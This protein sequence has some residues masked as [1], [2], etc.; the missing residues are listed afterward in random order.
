VL[1][2]SASQP[3]VYINHKTID[4]KKL[5]PITRVLI[6]ASALIMVVTYFVPIWQILMWAPQYPEGL[7][8]KIWLYTLSGDYKIISGLN[9][10]I[11]MKHIEVDMFPE[12]SYMVYFVGGLM[13]FG[14][15]AAVVNRRFMLWSY[16]G[17]I[18]FA[19]VAG[20]V[21]FY[22]W[23][24]DYGHNLDPAAP[25][26][27]PGMAYQPP[28]LGT[29]QLLNFTAYSGPDFGG[30]IFALSGILAIAGIFL[31]RE[32]KKKKKPEAVVAAFAC[33][34]TLL[35]A[36]CSSGP[37][38]L[39]FGKDG[40]HFCKMT[41]MDH[42]FGS[43]VVTAK[44]KIFKFDDVTCLNSFLKS[45]EVPSDQVSEI[46]IVD[47]AKPGVFIDARNAYYVT[48]EEIKSP[49]G[50]NTAAFASPEAVKAINPKWDTSV[51]RWEDVSR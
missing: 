36:S 8:M 37:E 3:G 48:N 22:Q 2:G 33:I 30:Y 38:P 9:H 42:K 1:A 4:M 21:D 45:E 17:L 20:L 5:K 12:F 43:E 29:K 24:Y 28:L 41:L 16:L 34:T 49:M 14:V 27:V 25:I 46:V 26:I 40:C 15:I 23:G 39:A 51:R 18:L 44:G 35:F 47:F 10:Y 6:I 7:E 50:S 32:S 11:G 19:G 13:A 31:E